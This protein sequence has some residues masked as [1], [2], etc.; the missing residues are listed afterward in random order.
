MQTHTQ[1]EKY[2]RFFHVGFEQTEMLRSN[3]KEREAIRMN[4]Y[5]IEKLISASN[6][7]NELAH[8]LKFVNIDSVDFL[9]NN[10]F[11]DD[12]LSHLERL[13]IVFYRLSGTNI[14]YQKIKQIISQIASN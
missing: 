1:C 10:H 6:F 14:D 12:Y 13:I 4:A 7:M 9:S 3:K 2:Q 11:Q 5:E 8:D